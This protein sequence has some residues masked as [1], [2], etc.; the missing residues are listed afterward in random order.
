M[1]TPFDPAFASRALLLAT[2]LGFASCQSDTSARS[3]ESGQSPASPSRTRVKI[4]SELSAT[5]DVVAIDRDDRVV[6]LRGEDGR[7]I[8]VVAGPEVR[9]FDRIAVGNKLRVRYEQSLTAT[10]SPPGENPG[11][12]VAAVGAARAKPGE[13]PAGGLGVAFSLRVR[14]ESVDVPNNIVVASPGSGDLIAHR[15]ATP[16][17]REFVRGL[18]IGDVVRL[19]Y[20]EALALAIEP[21]P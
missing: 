17:G 11:P 12:A 7:L 8:E 19:D 6:T 20:S 18:K 13:M 14:I 9:N 4:S 1:R 15:I 10:L 2:F 3:K 21:L 5:A 16:E